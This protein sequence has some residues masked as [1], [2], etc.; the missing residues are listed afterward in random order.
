MPAPPVAIIVLHWRNYTATHRCLTNLCALDY[1]NVHII[2][3]DNGSHDGKFWRLVQEFP[4]IETLEYATNRGFAAGINPAIRRAREL[5][6]AFVWLVN[7]DVT[8]APNTLTRLIE[9]Q[10]QYP[11]VGI[12]APRQFF[13]ERPDTTA[14][15]GVRLGPYDIQL[16]GWDTP[17]PTPSEVALSRLMPSLRR[18]C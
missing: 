18:Q 14:G 6:S 16:V 5:G 2:V 8:L 4:A 17:D 13:T 3:A 9:K 10:Q 7:N 12:L 15:L 1:P 11:Q